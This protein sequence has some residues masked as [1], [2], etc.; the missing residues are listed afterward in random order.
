MVIIT[1]CGSGIPFIIR[2]S[3]VADRFETRK[4]VVRMN[5]D[6]QKLKKARKRYDDVTQLF[7]RLYEDA[8]EGRLSP[9][10]QDRLM[11]KYQAEQDQ[12]LTL[13]GQ[14]EKA[15]RS[16]KDAEM[17][18]VRWAEEMAKL[19][20]LKELNAE[21]INRIISKIEVSSRQE[22]DGEVLQK[23]KITY[24]FGGFISDHSFS[25]WH[26]VHPIGE[27]WHRARGKA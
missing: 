18:A 4:V 12:L 6:E 25:A 19:I 11:Q 1:A 21:L 20:D 26:Y 17:N 23:I 5:T 13:I 16:H 9:M 22:A 7:D 3:S 24:R 10:N 15:L 8:L 14:L 2:M 27:A